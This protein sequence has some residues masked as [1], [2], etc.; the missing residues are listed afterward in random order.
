MPKLLQVNVCA[1]WGSTGRIAEQIGQYAISQGWE[2][3]IA[4]GR[5]CNPSTSNLI[6]IGSMT[7]TVFH[8]FMGGMFDMEGRWS[9]WST[10]RFLKAIDSISP[11]VI[12]IHNIHDHYLNFPLLFEHLIPTGIPIV[13][14][15]HDIWAVTGHCPFNCVE[16]DKWKSECF[17]CPVRCRWGMDRSRLNYVY[18]KG[19]F[20][21]Y[22]NLTVVPV[23]S[24][25]ESQIRQSFFKKS[26][27]VPITNGVD[28]NMFKP[29]SS[30]V[31]S[32]MGLKD[33]RIIIGVASIW[34]PAKGLN[35]YVELSKRLSDDWRIVL[36]GIDEKTKSSLPA[37]IIGVPMTHDQSRLAE[38]YSNANVVMSLS[39]YETFGLTIA[40]GLACGTPAIVYD[41][42]A[43][44]G[45]VDSDT[46]SVVA[47]GDINGVLL[48]LQKYEQKDTQRIDLCR[49]RAESLYSRQSN[50]EK[51]LK[52]YTDLV[53]ERNK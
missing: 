45:M 17:D 46:G 31:Y 5:T 33:K 22:P 2:S 9:R 1:N 12:H 28:I 36:V 26:R 11:D 23:S 37:N 49:S 21:S 41:N 3:C 24:W 51:Y 29:I 52:L 20:L 18:K 43:Q 27:I 7:D 39:K 47:D 53:S 15:M 6:K 4:Y 48:E 34:N 35:D 40:E 32:E 13:W 19:L 44:P 25:L 14:T 42:T 50:N 16:C 30:Q 10:R 8:Y 38:L